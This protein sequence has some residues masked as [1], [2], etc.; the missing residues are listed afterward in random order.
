MAKKTK[1]ENR[2]L[3]NFFTLTITILFSILFVIFNSNSLALSIILICNACITCFDLS[4]SLKHKVITIDLVYWIFNFLFFIIAVITQMNEIFFPNTLPVS[5]DAILTGQLYLFIWN[6]VYFITRNKKVIIPISKSNININNRIANIYFYTSTFLVFYIFLKN[7]FQFFLGNGSIINGDP[8]EPVSVLITSVVNSIVFANFV[9]QFSKREKG[10][11]VNKLLIVI[12]FIELT[13]INSPFNTSRFYL[14][15]LIIF[16]IWY[17]Y[18]HLISSYVF[19]FILLVGVAVIFPFLDLFRYGFETKLKFSWNNTVEQF[20][21]LHF[22]AFSNFLASIEYVERYGI[23]F[24]ENILGSFLFFIPRGVWNNKPEGSGTR[25][26][27]YLIENY[28]LNFNNLSNPLIS[29]FY[30]GF[31]LI[32][33]LMGA[34]LLATFINQI[35]QKLNNHLFVEIFYGILMSYLFF[36]LRGSL[37]VAVASIVA[38]TL[39]MVI[40]PR[41]FMKRYKD[42][43]ILFNSVN[44]DHEKKIAVL[45]DGS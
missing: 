9:F 17:F 10:N 15:F 3:L 31:G 43:S 14:G 4:F 12:A 6:F 21:Q 30:L 5:S 25:I 40:I 35:E 42:K 2:T 22:D 36:L 7:G 18:R 16:F 27:D 33:I 19:S 44:Y 11:F 1:G 20:N 8:S 26:G 41:L 23:L 37:I 32:G 28:S 34:F 39:F 13:Y 45:K 24:G 38:T 29:E